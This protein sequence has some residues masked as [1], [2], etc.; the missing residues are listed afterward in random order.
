MVGQNDERE[1]P[2]EEMIQ[3]MYKEYPPY[4]VAG[5]GSAKVDLVSAIALLC[6]YC[7]SLPGDKYTCYT[8]EWY[9][10]ENTFDNK[11]RVVIFL[12]VISQIKGPIKVCVTPV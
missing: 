3:E 1:N 7:Q 9:E 6:R 10:E 2:S 4:F 8:P 11:K 5:P 12:P